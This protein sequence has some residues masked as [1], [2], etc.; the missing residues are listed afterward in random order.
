M[1]LR[2]Y[3]IGIV[4]G[5]VVGSATAK[6]YVEHVKQVKIFDIDPLRSTARLDETL[7]S[8]IVFVCLPTPHHTNSDKCDL[9]YLE[10]FFEQFKMHEPSQV[11]K[12]LVLRSTVPVGYTRSVQKKLDG[13]AKVV[14]SPEFLTARC[15]ALDAQIPTRNIVGL[16]GDGFNAPTLRELYSLR[17]PHVPVLTM[18]CYE[19]EAVK[20]FTN[21]FFAV[22]IAFWNEMRQ[23]IDAVNDGLIDT[24]AIVMDWQTIMEAVLLDGR[25]HPSH[26]Q[27]PGP[28]GRY[29]LGG[30]CLPKDLQNTIQ[31]LKALDVDSPVCTAAAMRN[32]ADRFLMVRGRD[33]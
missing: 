1:D 29:G 14:H 4:G 16:T 13:Y 28:D 22:K 26:T 21:S 5:G 30:A 6:S 18:S 8:D 10:D 17:W 20:L 12:V 9:S 31:C 33:A 3:T 2:D 23:Y 11:T 15:A 24:C 27:V 19:S 32:T 7:Q 25:I